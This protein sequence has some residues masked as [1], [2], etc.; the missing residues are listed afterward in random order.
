MWA[1][2]LLALERGHLLRLALWGAGCVTAGVLLMALLWL[3]RI[4]APLL[5]HFAMQL[6]LWGV[7]ELAF[8]AWGWRVV[9]LRDLAG[10]QQL[11]NFLW[12]NTGLSAGYV[13]TG[14][15][16]ALCS[17]RFGVRL[18]GMGAGA[19]IAVHGMA[20]LLLDVRLITLIGPLQ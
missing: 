15:A 2:T 17:W 14:A 7:V 12:L 9:S 4:H 16:L 13:M 20:M 8:S 5:H 1:D 18:A 11:V 6:A 3:R 19:A 10:A